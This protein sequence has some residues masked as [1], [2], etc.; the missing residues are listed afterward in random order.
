MHPFFA[1]L[2]DQIKFTVLNVR[3]SFYEQKYWLKFYDSER[4]YTVLQTEVLIE[5]SIFLNCRISFFNDN[6]A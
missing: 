2:T 5:I 3:I 6:T 1:S 4:C